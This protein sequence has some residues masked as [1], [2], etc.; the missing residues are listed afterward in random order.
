ME[1]VPFRSIPDLLRHQANRLD[2]RLAVKYRKQGNWVTLSYS[3]FFTRALMVARGLRKLGI[4]P[5]DKVAILSENRVGWVIADMGILC[6]GAVTVPVY[7]TN[8]PE[9]VEY[10]LN[11]GDARIVFI[12]GKSQY[13]KLLK[14]KDAIPMVELVVSFERFLGEPSLPLTT[15]YQLSEIDDPI[16]DQEREELYAVI[17]AIEPESLMTIIYTS[18]TTGVPKG[19]MLSHRNIL[20]DV[21][22]TIEKAAV[23][24]GEVFLSFLP[25]SH[26]LERCTGYYLPIARGAM[27]AFADSIEKIAE[28]MLEIQPTI[29]VCVPRLFEKIHSRIYEHV[30]QLSLYKRKLFGTVLSIGRRYVHARYIEKK[31]P[32]WLAIQ[33]AVADR[34]VFSK[35]RERFGNNLKFCSSGGAPLDREINE[36]FWSIGVPILEG[37]GLTETSPVV[38]N[39]TFGQLRFGSVGTPLGQTDFRVAEDGEL[40]VRGPQVML[41]YYK[42]EAGTREAFS[43]GWLRTGDI[44]RIEEGFVVITDRKKDLIVTAGGKNIAPQPIENL[45]KRDKYI[46]QAYVYGDKR[47]Y[48]TALLVPTLE[49]LLEFAQERRIAYTDLEELVVHD[50]VLELYRQRVEAVNAELAHY[51]TIKNFVLLPRDFTLESGELTPTLK[52]KRR[53]I[54]ERYKDKIERMYTVAEN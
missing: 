9:Q 33:H 54:S 32:L 2:A 30:H 25:L 39:N 8:S 16:S 11:H 20:F 13:R 34:V 4:K 38:C 52:V 46:S 19:V 53:V 48:L 35:L 1:K 27:I 51:E 44:G 49:K 41:G 21:F 22:A 42:D 50:P 14:I 29:M 7:A 5:G 12:S 15:F 43:D 3:Q 23:Q 10:T 45:L 26:V 31:V 18:G 40:L 37:Y 24:E 36:F 47:P 28:N 6:A 17:D